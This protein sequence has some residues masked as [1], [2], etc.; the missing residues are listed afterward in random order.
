[1][2]ETPTKLEAVV[3]QHFSPAARVRS[4]YLLE[5]HL[6]AVW[7]LVL[8]NEDRLLLKCSPNSTTPLLRREQ[9]L[10]DTEARVIALLGQSSV[11]GVPSLVH[12][13]SHGDLLDS[14]FLIRRYVAGRTQREME[15]Q[16]TIQNRQDIDRRLG[17]L[18][19]R[20]GQHVSTS[21][22]TV[23]Q[24]ASGRGKRSWK[25]AF[26]VLFES[27]L[28]DAEDAF[29]NI[30]YSEIRH[31]V[32][33]LS[34]ELEAVTLPR[35]VVVDF[36]RPSQVILD[37]E[38]RQVSGVIDFSNALWGDVQM[39][40]IFDE[41]SSAV[42]DGFGS[43]SLRGHSDVRQLLYACYRCVQ[44][45]TTQYYRDRDI[46]ADNQARRRLTTIVR[47]MKEID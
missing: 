26:V 1:M 40:E 7:V 17:L 9:H 28:R 2:I 25:E 41:P 19:N 30:P 3:R 32:R 8:S 14:S 13:D 27:V 23:Q 31:H 47:E 6:H 4:A 35:L 29:V 46:I 22:G 16:L 18:A 21:F 44:M 33:R 5:G 37:P 10:L 43:D 11:P 20:I 42:L 45:I 24:V 12:Y 34:T 38:S 15:T 36:G 39:A